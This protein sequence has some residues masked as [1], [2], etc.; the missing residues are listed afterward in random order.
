MNLLTLVLSGIILPFAVI[1][2][3]IGINQNHWVLIPSALAFAA[4]YGLRRLSIWWRTRNEQRAAIEASDALAG[5]LDR[6]ASPGFSV[7]VGGSRNLG[8]VLFA[9]PLLALMLCGCIALVIDGEHLIVGLLATPVFGLFLLGCLGE[10]VNDLRSLGKPLL[11]LTHAGFETASVGAVRWQEVEGLHLQRLDHNRSGLV[12][13]YFWI[14]IRAST[15]LR[16]QVSPISWLF[17][18]LRA[19]K[20]FYATNLFL[21]NTSLPPDVIYQLARALWRQATGHDH[22]WSPYSSNEQNQA[23]RDAEATTQKLKALNDR[24]TPATRA[25][26]QQATELLKSTAS[27]LNRAA[28]ESKRQALFVAVLQIAGAL[29][30]VGL[31]IWR[32]LR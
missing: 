28:D 27:A 15:Q 31:L 22:E 32:F 6:I 7:E 29:A 14:R 25:E 21:R 4:I 1:A 17:Y 13:H 19:R 26:L 10:L 30:V 23:L 20:G 3:L 24:T 5:L 16:S 11:A 18:P 12:Y 2:L 9:T 8:I